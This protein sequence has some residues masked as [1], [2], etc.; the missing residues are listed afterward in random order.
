MRGF[1]KTLEESRHYHKTKTTNSIAIIAIVAALALLGVVAITVVVIII[2]IIIPKQK[3][4]P[5][6]PALQVHTP[7]RRVQR[8]TETILPSQVVENRAVHIYTDVHKRTNNQLPYFSCLL[9]PF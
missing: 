6:P 5:P 7:I 4:K 1:G 8:F 9:P 2:I 3:Q